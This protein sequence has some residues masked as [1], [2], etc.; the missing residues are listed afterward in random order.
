MG[1]TMGDNGLKRIDVEPGIER[2]GE[3]TD[4]VEGTLTACSV[5]MKNSTV[6]T[7]AVMAESIRDWGLPLPKDFLKSREVC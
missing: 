7:T 2:L 3:V 1:G 5:P 6:V 4:F